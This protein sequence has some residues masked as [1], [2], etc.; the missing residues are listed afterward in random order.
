MVLIEPIICHSGDLCIEYK[1]PAKY[2]ILV[3]N[4]NDDFPEYYY[5]C[6]ICKQRMVKIKA[7]PESKF[8]PL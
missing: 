8:E 7:Y 1:V 2:T 6:E 4:T 5:Y 3:S